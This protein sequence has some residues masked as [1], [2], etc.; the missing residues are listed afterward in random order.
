MLEWL[1]IFFGLLVIGLVIFEKSCIQFV[2]WVLFLDRMLEVMDV[3]VVVVLN[4]MFLL[5]LVY[6]VDVLSEFKVFVEK[7]KL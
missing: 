7:V 2:G 4:D 5:D 6:I 1:N 3:V